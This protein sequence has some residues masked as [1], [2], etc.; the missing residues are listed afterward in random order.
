M[1]SSPSRSLKTLAVQHFQPCPDVAAHS[2]SSCPKLSPTEHDCTIEKLDDVCKI[3]VVL[4]D[5]VP[6][7]LHQ[8]QGYEEHV[9]SGGDVSS[10]PDGLPDSKDVLIHQ[11]CEQRTTV[12]TPLTPA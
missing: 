10:S 6:V 7:H 8:G 2:L 4:Q 11:L 9:V 12:S 3:H 5:D 1:E